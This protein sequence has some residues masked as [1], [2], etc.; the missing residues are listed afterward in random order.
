[1]ALLSVEHIGLFAVL[2]TCKANRA[3]IDPDHN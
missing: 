1:V 2:G 3:R